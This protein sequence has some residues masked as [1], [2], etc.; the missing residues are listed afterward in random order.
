MS[1]KVEEYIKKQ[2]L[3]Q[4]EILLKLRDLIFKTFSNIKEEFKMGVP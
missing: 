2:E 4:R 1:Q 3:P